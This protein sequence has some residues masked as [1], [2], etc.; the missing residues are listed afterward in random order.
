MLENFYKTHDS[1]KAIKTSLGSLLN[2]TEKVVTGEIKNGFALIR[3][4]GHHAHKTHGSGF[5]FLSNV[6][7]TALKYAE[8]G[9]RIAIYDFD[10][11][12]GDGTKDLVCGK[13]NIY[14]ISTHRHEKDK[15]FYP[16]TG[17]SI[18]KD[19]VLQIGIPKSKFTNDYYKDLFYKQIAPNIKAYKPNIIL[20]SAGYDACIDD[21]LGECGLAPWLYGEIT[22]ELSKICS[23]LVLALEG[24]YNI[25]AL[26]HSIYE[27]CKELL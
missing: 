5:C 13:K 17:K 11:H 3:P 22:K 15:S 21:P 2:L 19:N 7:L 9:Y 12:F 1:T 14:Y 24:G 8:K 27:T 4:P 25:K 18:V 23:K 6:A 16:S 10:V 20:V 26:Q